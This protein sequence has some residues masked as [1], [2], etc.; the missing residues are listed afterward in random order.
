MCSSPN[1]GENPVLSSFWKCLLKMFIF[2][3]WFQ[4]IRFLHKAAQFNPQMLLKVNIHVNCY[5]E[6]L[7]YH[8]DLISGHMVVV[9]FC[10]HACLL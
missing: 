4:S 6:A 8:L 3:S 9:L 7:F 2:V 5:S 1:Y 10:I